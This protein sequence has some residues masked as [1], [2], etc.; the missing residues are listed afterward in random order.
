MSRSEYSTV[1]LHAL[2]LVPANTI[3]WLEQALGHHFVQKKR[4]KL[5]RGRGPFRYTPLKC[6]GDTYSTSVTWSYWQQDLEE[7]DNLMNQSFNDEA[8]HGT[9]PATPGL[10]TIE[11]LFWYVG[12]SPIGS[13][14][15]QQTQ[16][17]DGVTCNIWFIV[18]NLENVRFVL[19]NRMV[20]MFLIMQ[21]IPVD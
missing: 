10:L 11:S 15:P 12:P 4:E 6:R 16:L 3:Y 20:N 18:F 7:K 9:V 2:G 14:L 8:V 17:L 1:Q 5:E 19:K 21:W 13:K